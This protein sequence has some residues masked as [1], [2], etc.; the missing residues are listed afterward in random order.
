M[1]LFVRVSVFLPKSLFL[2]D[3]EALACFGERL[4]IEE[5][6]FSVSSTLGFLEVFRKTPFL[7]NYWILYKINRWS[8][9]HHFLM[10]AVQSR[11][12]QY[13]RYL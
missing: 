12:L 10:K 5:V 8:I 13:L 9:D 2:V 1:G 3:R 7:E 4:R 6:L 11:L